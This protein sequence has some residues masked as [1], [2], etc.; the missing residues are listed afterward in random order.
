LQLMWQNTEIYVLKPNSS[1]QDTLRPFRAHV[2]D[3]S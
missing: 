3:H 1:W 2:S